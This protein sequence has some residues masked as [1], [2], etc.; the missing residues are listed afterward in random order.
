[1]VFFKCFKSNTITILAKDGDSQDEGTTL[2]LYTPLTGSKALALL[3]KDN[4]MYI[5]S[6]SSEVSW[7]VVDSVRPNMKKK[8]C[9]SRVLILNPSHHTHDNHSASFKL[10]GDHIRSGAKAWNGTLSTTGEAVFDEFYWVWLEDVLSRSKDVLTNVGLY[11]A[12][13]ASLFSYDRHPSVLRAFFEHWCST[14]NTLHTAQGEM[15]ISLWD[16]HRIGGLL[17]QGKFYDEV[18]LSAKELSLCYNRGL[19]ASCR[20]LFW[21]YHKLFQDAQGKLGVRN[22]SWIRFWYWEAMRYK[23]PL[24][25]NGH[26]KTTRPN[27]DSDPSG[28]IGSTM[29]RS[30]D[31]LKAFEDLGITSEHVEESCLAAFLACWL[32]KFVF[33]TGDVNLVCLGV[34]KVASKMA[35]GESFSLAILVLNNIYNG[36]SIVSNS[37][38]TEDRVAVLPYH[39]VYGW[40]GEYFGTHFSLLTLDKSMPFSS[41]RAKLRP[42]M[43]KYSGVLPAKSLDDLQAR[44]LFKRCEDLKI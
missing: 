3:A 8:A 19:P 26:N 18:V 16:L 40:L 11:H 29:R 7:E 10:L 2:K 4:S 22:S 37:A 39:Y 42:L 14:T 35:A 34:F 41:I 28:V 33:P 32:C 21:A 30:S 43:M 24:K 27:G 23:K 31:K 44:A 6:W 25:K 38:S 15:S 9:I 20:C 17:I 36:L 1:M 5:K 13:Y 12:V